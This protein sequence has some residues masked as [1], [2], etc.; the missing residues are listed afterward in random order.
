MSPRSVP[1][2]DSAAEGK[3][4]SL[5]PP[6]PTCPQH[7]TG[8][9]LWG[10]GSSGTWQHQAGEEPGGLPGLG[11]LVC[12]S[13]PDLPP[14]RGAESTAE[15]DVLKN[16]ELG[17]PRAGAPG[18]PAL[19][20]PAHPLALGSPHH[21]PGPCLS[22]GQLQPDTPHVTCSQLAID[23]ERLPLK[24]QEL[25]YTWGNSSWLQRPS[26]PLQLPSLHPGYREGGVTCISDPH[27]ALPLLKTPNTAQHL[28]ASALHPESSQF[29]PSCPSWQGQSPQEKPAPSPGP[30]SNAS[31]RGSCHSPQ[32]FLP[33]FSVG[34]CTQCS[35][36]GEYALPR[37]PCPDPASRKAPGASTC[38]AKAV[39]RASLQPR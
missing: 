16:L 3:G 9:G 30:S 13:R 18:K 15:E 33:H 34:N 19:C 32:G 11:F 10:P 39:S 20:P 29:S 6:R 36:P 35:R 17:L 24:P 28:T 2:K 4:P 8:P 12:K 23:M 27:A 1:L 31:P 26:T 22:Q 14:T 7:R 25:D 38:W 5:C 37:K 21:Q